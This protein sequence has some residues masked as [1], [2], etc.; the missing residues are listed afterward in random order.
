MI[1][2]VGW[3]PDDV[4]RHPAIMESPIVDASPETLTDRLRE[5]VLDPDRRHRL[6]SDGREYVLRWHTEAVSAFTWS[7]IVEALWRGRPVPE[8]SRP[9]MPAAQISP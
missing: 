7:S 4:R 3:F 5:L 6:G 2:N 1:S 9:S 8:E